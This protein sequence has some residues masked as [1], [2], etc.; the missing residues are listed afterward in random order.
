MDFNDFL[1][2]AGII[3]VVAGLFYS[4]RG[5]KNTSHVAS[6]PP[7]G[8]RRTRTGSGGSVDSDDLP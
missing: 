5:K 2:V 3:I 8:P 6:P 4:M 1:I 7:S